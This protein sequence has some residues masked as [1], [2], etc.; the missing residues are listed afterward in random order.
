MRN[1]LATLLLSTGVPMLVAGDER[2]PHPGRQQQRLLPGQRDRPGSTGRADDAPWQR[3]LLELTARLLALRREHPVLR[4]RHFF[5]GRPAIGGGPKDLAWFHPAGREMT[6]DDWYDAGLRT[7]GMFV[8]GD[9]L[10]SPGPRGEQLRDTGFL[11]WLNGSPR[12]A[13]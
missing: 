1:L 12:T 7:I 10:R 9:P 11:V 8:S 6:D 3:D 4:Q 13:R 5:E 2:G